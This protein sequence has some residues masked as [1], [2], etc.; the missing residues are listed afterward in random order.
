MQFN[1][2]MLKQNLSELKTLL[3]TPT[4]LTG[5]LLNIGHA[6]DHM[7]LLIFAV[8]VSSIALDFGFSSWE[9]LMPYSVGAFVFFGLGALPA[10]RLGD[11]YG[12]RILMAIFFFGMGVT[13]ILVSLSQNP[14]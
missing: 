5:L 11:L 8:A 12:R 14:W 1:K 2:L 7:F 10:G 4:G 6:I 13:S 9:D 3:T